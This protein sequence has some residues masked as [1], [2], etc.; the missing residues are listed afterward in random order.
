M[1]KRD[2]MKEAHE[3]AAAVIRQ[4]VDQQG[5]G[6]ADTEAEHEAVAAALYELADRHDRAALATRPGPSAGDAR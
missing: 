3:Q 2:A 6:V 1:R 5:G 4:Y